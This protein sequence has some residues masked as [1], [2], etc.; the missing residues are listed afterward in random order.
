MLESAM[1]TAIRHARY[2]NHIQLLL[3]LLLLPSIALHCSLIS[4]LLLVL[5]YRVKL[6]SHH[7]N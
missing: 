3:L 5:L 6:R 4:S 1:L 7:T 2:A